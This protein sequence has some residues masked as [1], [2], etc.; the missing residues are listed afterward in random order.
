LSPLAPILLSLLFTAVD[1]GVAGPAAFER[2]TPTPD[3]ESP[4]PSRN[5][6]EPRLPATAF[7]VGRQP[8]AWRTKAWTRPL[9]DFAPGWESQYPEVHFS[10]FLN[11]AR[12]TFHPP[13]ERDLTAAEWRI[14][15]YHF[16]SAVVGDL[17]DTLS[18]ACPKGRCAP[19]LDQAN[20]Q[21]ATFTRSNAHEFTFAERNTDN[22]HSNVSYRWHMTGAGASFD[23]GCDEVTE[24]PE[25]T[26]QMDLELADGLVL[27]YQPKNSMTGPEPD[28]AVGR[29]GDPRGKPLGEVRF[30]R[31]YG[32]APVVVLVGAALAPRAKQ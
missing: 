21:L 6:N 1:G 14:A 26:C 8:R 13:K 30:E 22:D 4:P 28:I 29:Q 19:M 31:T 27:R 9:R 24:A 2:T 25:V 32:G 11:L 5:A 12:P 10:R 3:V 23:L 16:A 15:L 17:R 7:P 18:L 20:Q